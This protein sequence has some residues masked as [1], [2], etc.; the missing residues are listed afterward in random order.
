[1]GRLSAE[2]AERFGVL[3][4]REVVALADRFV[5]MSQFAVD[6]LRTDVDE[7]DL[8]KIV[9]V[10]FAFPTARADATPASA[11]APVVAT[12]GVVNE[13]KQT[14]LLVE[15][16]PLLR[17]RCP[18]AT[19]AVVG[20]CGDEERARLEALADA[21]GVREHL[22]I[23]SDVSDDEYRTWLDRAAVA[24]QLRASANGECSAAVTDCVAAGAALVVSNVGSGRELDDAWV[25]KVE[26][27][28][29]VAELA[30]AVAELLTDADR[31]AAMAAAGREHACDA[32]FDA[33][34]DALVARAIPQLADR[35]RPADGCARRRSTRRLPPPSRHRRWAA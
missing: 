1:L 26:T 21:L 34:A 11:R 3:M 14:S 22:T 17:I 8:A 24:V 15:A 27:E 18:D 4:A 29:G 23:A 33:A 32:T 16:L 31:R 7:R 30:A 2:L 35:A 5:V 6:L 20:H 19:L 13:V 10:P 12:F 28:V 9:T 25:Y